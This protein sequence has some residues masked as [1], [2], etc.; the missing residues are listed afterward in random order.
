LFRGAAAAAATMGA[1]QMLIWGFFDREIHTAALLLVAAGVWLL[2]GRPLPAGDTGGASLWGELMPR[3][4]ALT[5]RCF[6]QRFDLYPPRAYPS[7]FC[8]LMRSAYQTWKGVG[9]VNVP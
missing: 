5:V 6:L 4:A 8:L 1:V 9:E 3:R 7:A 2:P